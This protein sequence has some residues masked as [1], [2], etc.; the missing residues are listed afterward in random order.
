MPALA[1]CASSGMRGGS[2]PSRPRRGF[3]SGW[4]TRALAGR[5]APAFSAKDCSRRQPRSTS[6][7]ARDWSTG[8]TIPRS[9][10]WRGTSRASS[11]TIPIG[12]GARSHRSPRT[13]PTRTGATASRGPGTARPSRSTPS[14]CGRGSSAR[15]SDPSCA[16]TPED[17][18]AQIRTYTEG[19][20]VETV[21]FWASI[22]G[23]PEQDV[24]R[25]VET[26]CGRLAPLLAT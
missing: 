5:A 3:P 20:P 11:P 13:R 2:R 17:A 22:A 7:T 1:S 9:P 15:S 16:A 12:S 10:A 25:H 8:D 14:G 19:A 18:A 6:R 24:V 4:G 26:I 21:F 23:M